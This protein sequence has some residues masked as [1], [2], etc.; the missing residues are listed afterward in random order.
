LAGE[1]EVLGENLPQCRFVHH[2]PHMLLVREPGAA[3]VG[4]IHVD[5][6]RLMDTENLK[7]FEGTKCSINVVMK[8]KSMLVYGAE[9]MPILLCDLSSWSSTLLQKSPVVLLL[10]NFPPF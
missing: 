6:G 5:P 3:A 8:R 2:K 10:K 4:I 1:T 9:A 7:L